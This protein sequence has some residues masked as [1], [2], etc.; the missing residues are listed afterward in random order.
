MKRSIYTIL[1]YKKTVYLNDFECN[2]IFLN[3]HCFQVWA[4]N[5]SAKWLQIVKR[6]ILDIGI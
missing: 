6:H 1:K 3:Y 4:F 2:F 5:M